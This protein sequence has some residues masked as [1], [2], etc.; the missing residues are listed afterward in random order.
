MLLRQMQDS[1]RMTEGCYSMTFNCLLISNQSGVIW[2]TT[3]NENQM[4][5]QMLLKAFH[6]GNSQNDYV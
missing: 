4:S 2:D 3:F 1:L 5:F 6:M